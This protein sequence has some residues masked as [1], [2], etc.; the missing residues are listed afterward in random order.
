[1]EDEILRIHNEEYRILKA[2]N[3]QLLTLFE[4]E[5]PRKTENHGSH[6]RTREV[7]PPASYLEAPG[8]KPVI[9]TYFCGFP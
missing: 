9:L 5:A 4:N 1:M 6:D 7:T 8:F 3:S 2:I